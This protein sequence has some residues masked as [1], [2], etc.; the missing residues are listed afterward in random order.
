MNEFTKR[1]RRLLKSGLESVKMQGKCA[2][3]MALGPMWRWPAGKQSHQVGFLGGF[4]LVLSFAVKRK[5]RK[6]KDVNK[7]NAL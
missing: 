6:R 7:D 1:A 2:N 4:S 5:D 3:R